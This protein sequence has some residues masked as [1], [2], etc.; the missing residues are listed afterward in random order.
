MA[1]SPDGIVRLLYVPLDPTQQHQIRFSDRGSQASWFAGK[2]RHTY[3]GL[4]FSKKDQFITVPEN[5]DNLW[6]CNYVMYNNYNYANRWFYAFIDRIEY[7]SEGSTRVYIRTD[8]YQT[9]ML[10][11]TFK[12]SFVVREHVADDTIGLHTFPEGLET[13][14]LVL[15]SDYTRSLI[16][17]LQIVIAVT[18]YWNGSAWAPASGDFYNGI[19][20][21]CKLYTFSSAGAA[22]TFI[23]NYVDTGSPGGGGKAEAIIAM[24]MIPDDFFSSSGTPAAITPASSSPEIDVTGPKLP[25]TIDG[26]TPKNNKLFTFP[27]CFLYVHNNSGQA[28]VYHFEDFSDTPA[29]KI[30]GGV[31]P[32]PSYKL[33][34]YNLSRA[35]QYGWDESLT[36]AG[37][38]MCSWN[39][40]V[41]KNWLGQNAGSLAVQGV[42]SLLSIVGGAVGGSP[43]AIAQGVMGAASQIAGIYQH[44][45]L[46]N[47]ANGNLNAGAAN[48]SKDWMDFF[49]HVKTIKAE[50]AQMIDEFLTM[51]GY[52]V[53][54]VKVPE[55]SSRPAWNFVQT[56]G[57]NILGDIPAADL[58]ELK[59]LFDK[60]ITLWHSGDNV[61]NYST[62]NTIVE[63]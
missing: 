16:G 8:V 58:A 1:M 30:Y 63:A 41:Y 55:L 60:G 44:S 5:I 47:Q 37:F 14:P 3:S 4:T 12:P 59:G 29:F 7:A 49:L 43:M 53:N 32:N 28:A 17:D 38:P 26:Y 24:Y 42:G 40:D 2:A 23:N 15:S 34:P 56:S 57:A 31:L 52:K 21:G 61:G 39:T 51:Y 62:D 35:P 6:D 36:L 19:Y 18:E 20:S 25:E 10:D 33:Y 9:W 46:P 13:G 11:S 54:R 48:A 22:N 50:Y 27:Y 45:L